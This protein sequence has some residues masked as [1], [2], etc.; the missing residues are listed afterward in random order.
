M[1][2]PPATSAGFRITVRGRRIYLI[3]VEPTGDPGMS[4]HEAKELAQRLLHAAAVAERRQRSG[5]ENRTV[6]SS[7]DVLMLDALGI[8]W[9][10]SEGDTEGAGSCCREGQCPPD[11][12]SL[13]HHRTMRLSSQSLAGRVREGRRNRGWA[14]AIPTSH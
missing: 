6:T 5:D 8:L 11:C 3:D 7:R 12:G 2:R 1:T 10:V 13:I 9:C 14:A 4:H